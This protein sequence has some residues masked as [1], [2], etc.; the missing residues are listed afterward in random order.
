MIPV[1]PVSLTIGAV[2][3]ASLFSLSIQCFDLIEIGQRTSIDYEIS[4]VKLSIEKRR[5]MVWGE[6][7]GWLM[8][9]LVE[10]EFGG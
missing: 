9:N 10:A 4:V 8:A 2:A 6:A 7:V 3:L 1:E 5:L